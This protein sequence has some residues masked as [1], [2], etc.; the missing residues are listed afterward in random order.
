MVDKLPSF[1]SIDLP[2]S[3]KDKAF[4]AIKEYI[5]A[6]KLKPGGIYSEQAVARELHISKT[7]IHQALAE[8]QSRGFLTILPR[9]GF[10]VNAITS[11]VVR[12]LF[13]LR[14]VLEPAIIRLVT[15]KLD[16]QSIK[17]LETWNRLAANTQ[18]WLQFLKYDRAFHLHLASLTENRFMIDALENVKD[19]SDWVGAEVVSLENRPEEA[20]REHGAVI[21]RLKTGDA[22]GAAEAMAEHLRVTEARFLANVKAQ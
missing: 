13:E 11:D 17:E 9:R 10:Q 18:D 1:Q 19:L 5:L 2:P 3:L 14:H 8:L 22:E 20:I 12:A 15:P 21:D 16:E 6:H 4:Q 7:P